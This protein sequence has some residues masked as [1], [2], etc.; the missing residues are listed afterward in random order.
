MNE[1]EAAP[2]VHLVDD[3]PQVAKALARLLR[4][5]GFRTAVSDSAEAFLAEC[6]LSEPGCLVLDVELPGLDG[7]ALQRQLNDGGRPWPIVFL[8][9]QGDIP[10]S[11]QAV[12]AGAVDFLT[13]PV[14]ADVL[15]A[16]V[17]AGVE[18]D[19]RTRESQAE[20][21][22]LR[23][24]IAS[25]TARER[26]VLAGLA[27]GR[28]NKQIAADLGITEP[29]VKFHRARI[30]ERMQAHTIAELMHLVARFEYTPDARTAAPRGET[31]HDG[32]T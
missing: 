22:A 13:K 26:D 10:M 15:I 28:L 6:D 9:G 21:A 12:K 30:M 17:R 11:V 25:L 32:P 29:T 27:A 5:H 18:Q 23:K 20:S 7:L 16:A 24:R 2:L 14:A 31:P 4:E 1:R 8:T 3:D 19:A